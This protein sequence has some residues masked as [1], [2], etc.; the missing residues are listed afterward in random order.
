MQPK[1]SPTLQIFTKLILY[2]KTNHVTKTP[3]LENL[4]KILEV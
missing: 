2:V 4:L 3:T 1:F